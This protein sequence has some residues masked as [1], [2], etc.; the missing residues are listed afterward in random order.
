MPK[1]KKNPLLASIEARYMGM[2]EIN[3]EVDMI[4]FV[5]TINDDLNVG[6]GRAGKLFNDF[7]ASKHEIASTIDKD[8]GNKLHEGDKQLLQVKRNIAKRLRSIFSKEDWQKAKV[9]FPFVREFWDCE[10]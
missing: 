10:L 6:P 2:L 9:M 8:Y 3:S 7:L 5:L 1:Q 4:A